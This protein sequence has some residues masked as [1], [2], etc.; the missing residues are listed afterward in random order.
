MNGAE[1]EV[2]EIHNETVMDKSAN[3]RGAFAYV[4]NGFGRKIALKESIT[5]RLRGSTL[6]CVE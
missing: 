6:Y 3:P 1:K 2:G 4:S 5:A